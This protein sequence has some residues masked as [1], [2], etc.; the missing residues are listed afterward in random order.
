VMMLK[1]GTSVN[2]GKPEEVFGSN[3]PK[4]V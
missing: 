1:N 3:I 2:K 4:I